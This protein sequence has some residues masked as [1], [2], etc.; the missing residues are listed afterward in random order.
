MNIVMSREMG[1]DGISL[2][3]HLDSNFHMTET[4]F[5]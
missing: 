1:F 3:S 4:I 5:I 2:T